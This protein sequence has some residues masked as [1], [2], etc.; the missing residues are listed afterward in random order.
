MFLTIFFFSP[1]SFSSCVTITEVVSYEGNSSRRFF[2]SSIYFTDNSKPV[3]WRTSE[4]ALLKGLCGVLSALRKSRDHF[5]SHRLFSN[6][7][8]LFDIFI[9]T[10][11]NLT[12]FLYLLPMAT[13]L[14]VCSFEF[15]FISFDSKA[16]AAMNYKIENFTH[17]H[18]VCEQRDSKFPS[19]TK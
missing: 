1:L 5:K 9:F 4:S 8:F 13:M 3:I 12:F 15:C 10:N 18:D 11:I 16:F 19:L 2:F 17:I 7:F 6:H 14:H